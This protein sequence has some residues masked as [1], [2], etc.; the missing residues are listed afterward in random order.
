M[1]GIRI[2]I[3]NLGDIINQ[4][5]DFFGHTVT[6]SGFAADALSSD[7]SRRKGKFIKG[8]FFLAVVLSAGIAFHHFKDEAVLLYSRDRPGYLSAK[9]Q[10]HAAAQAINRFLAPSDRILSTGEMRGFYFSND[11]VLEGDFSNFTHYADRVSSSAELASYLKEK[12]FTCV[13]TSN[14]EGRRQSRPGGYSLR[15]VLA[16]ETLWRGYFKRELIVASKD[17]RYVLYRVL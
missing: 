17:A 9:E 12:G 16:D 3:N 5:D 11:F 4:F 1:T 13:L 8:L 6:G 10:S 2:G 14:L 7:A 15:S